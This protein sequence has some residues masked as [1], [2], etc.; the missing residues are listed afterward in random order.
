MAENGSAKWL[1]AWIKRW[2]FHENELSLPIAHDSG[3][4]VDSDD[5]S[6][7][8]RGTYLYALHDS[9]SFGTR[10]PPTSRAPKAWVKGSLQTARVGLL[11]HEG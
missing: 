9:R 5:C 8:A 1:S 7:Q 2:E 11:Y 6:A 10:R 3:R 4:P